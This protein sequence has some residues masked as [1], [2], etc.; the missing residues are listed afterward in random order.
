MYDRGIVREVDAK[1]HRARVELPARG[2][3]TGW[4]DVLA[5]ATHVD[6]HVRLPRVGTQVAVLLD[7]HA[8]AG[9]VLGAVYSSADPT[10]ADT[11]PELE[12][13]AWGD[14]GLVEY[15]RETHVL[16]VTLP[17]GGLVELAGSDDAFALASLVL[18]ELTAISS[19]FGAHTHPPLA[20][21][22]PPG[23]GPVTGV[24]G[25]PSTSYSPSSVASERVKTGA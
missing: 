22:A 13:L 23:G 12:R 4:L 6:K 14:G 8:E 5:G 16:R 18:G 25:T 9:C 11:R 15:D 20:L 10:P 24:M 3:T 1:A 7:E 19:A 17:S 21:V 2:V